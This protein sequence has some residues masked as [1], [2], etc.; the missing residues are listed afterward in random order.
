M[1]IPKRTFSAD[2]GQTSTG[3]RGPDAIENDL[4]SL[5]K[6]LDPVKEGLKEENFNALAHTIND[7]IADVYANQG[8]PNKLFSW[9]AKQIKTITGG[10]TWSTTPPAT[11]TDVEAHINALAPHAGHDTPEGAQ[12]KADEALISAK[13]Y[14]DGKLTAH[15]NLNKSHGVSGI[16][17]GTTDTQTISNKTLGG[18]L[19]AGGYKIINLGTPESASDATSKG[20][21]DGEISTHIHDSRYY[22]K[23]NLQTSSQAQIHWE[24]ITNKP[25]FADSSWKP[26]VASKSEL[27]ITG[28]TVNDMRVV[29]NDGDG[30]SAIYR[31]KA[32]TGEI[33][34]Q[35]EKLA[36]LDW[37]NDH[38]A[39]VGLQDDDHLQYLRVDGT[40]ALTGDQDFDGFQALNMVIHKGTSFPDAPEVGQKFYRTDLND[41]YVY[42]GSVIGWTKTSGQGAIIRDLEIVAEEGQTVFDLSSEGTFEVGTNVMSVYKKNTNGKYEL[43]DED[44]YVESDSETITLIV[45]ASEGD[46]YY[47]KWFENRPEVINLAVQKD[48]SLQT[49]LNADM[50][51]GKHASEF[52]P[53]THLAEH[54]RIEIGVAPPENPNSK[55]FWY[56]DLGESIDFVLGGGLLIGNAS[57]DGSDDV[58][59]DENI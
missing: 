56:E 14:S 29:A 4:D 17:V 51:D 12:A 36:D 57:T 2:V 49:N 55:T 43:V 45:P 39:L 11:L 52:L 34:D 48:G 8:T 47:F 54:L 15:A 13:S 23:T 20:Y 50:L 41:E 24:N 21:V 59:F 6:C 5:I 42:K 35:W 19:N 7:S 37:T 53:S 32:T 28:N 44:D 33:D 27:P 3:T 26:A 30:K 22:T 18:D 38:G 31:C 25:N 46:T 16:I 40:R 10:A 9:L 58:W 1:S